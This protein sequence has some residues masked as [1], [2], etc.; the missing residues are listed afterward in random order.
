[1][2]IDLNADLGE[3]PHTNDHQIMPYL[4]SCNIACGGH[5]GNAESMRRTVRAAIAEGVEIGAHPSY[6]DRPNF[7]RKT[8]P[9]YTVAQMER[10]MRE[11]IEALIEILEKENTTLHHLK[12]HGALYNDL[13]ARTDLAEAFAK[14]IAKYYSTLK[15][16]CLTDS[17]LLRACRTYDLRAVPEGFADRAYEATDRL[18]SRSRPGAVLYDPEQVCA[19]ALDLAKGT[20]TLHDGTPATLQV[21]TICLHGDTPGAV[22]L[23][24]SI[25]QTLTSHGFHI[26]APAQ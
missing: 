12:P 18:R 8:P 21:E 26:A 19:Q 10:E 16:Y 22:A 7:G 4:S 23:S 24:S 2:Q 9:S 17:A 13:A 3:L 15:V 20:I 25:H 6:R 5:A 14:L 11:Q 1:M